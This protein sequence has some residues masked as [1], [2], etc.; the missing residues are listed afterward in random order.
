[1]KNPNTKVG[2]AAAKSFKVC[3]RYLA[4]K[5]SDRVSGQA[6][7]GSEAAAACITANDPT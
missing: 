2:R 5:F 6:S 4:G 7:G 1:M 3:S